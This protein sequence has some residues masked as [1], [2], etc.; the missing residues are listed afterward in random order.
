[1]PTARKTQISLET[2]PYYHC[3]SRCVRRAF[4]CGKDHFSGKDFEH[5]RQWI[6]DRLLDLAAIFAIDIAAYA[7]MSNHYHV[8]LHI[9][10]ERANNWSDI[11]VCERWHALFSGND[12]S[13]RYLKGLVLSPTEEQ[14]LQV[15]VDRWRDRLIDISWFMRCLNEPIARAA[16]RED[17][18]TGRFWEGRFKSQA[19]LDERALAA[20]MVYVDLNPIRSRLADSPETSAHTSI[21]RRIWVSQHQSKKQ[22]IELLS[23]A[24]NPRKNM[25]KGIPFRYTDYLELVDWTGRI[26]RDDKRG[27]IPANLPAILVRLN[28]NPKHW[29]YLAKDFESPFK[30][31]V[32]SVHHVKQACEQLGKRWVQGIRHCREYF[33]EP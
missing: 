21:Q 17:D 18:A 27:A 19:L 33:P 8:V 11:E 20:C 12:L 5:R 26:L 3:V 31:L 6:E 25:P 15:L 22:P 9:N 29:T 32:G 30:S 16:N 10:K 14:R 7:I 1:M 2:T 24:G 23:F 13:G 28:I 4:L